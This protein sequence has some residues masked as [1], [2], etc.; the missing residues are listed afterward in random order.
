MLTQLTVMK[1]T[2]DSNEEKN[3]HSSRQVGGIYE[4]S[5]HSTLMTMYQGRPITIIALGILKV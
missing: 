1:H 2:I 4:C 3:N 5:E